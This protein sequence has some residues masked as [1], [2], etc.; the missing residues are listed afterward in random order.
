MP[1]SLNHIHADTPMGANLVADGA[2]FRVWAPQAKAVYVLGDFN[3]RRRND[4]SLLTRDGQGHWRGFVRGVKDR[5]RYMF[6]VVGE[7]G[8]GLKRDPYARELES[9]FPAE[10]IIRRTDF[11]WHESGYVTPPFHE[12]V[13]Y[14]LH[15]GTF[16]T[17]NLPRKG[18]TFLDVARKVP[19]LAELGV[20]ALQLMPIQEFQTSFSLGYNGTDYFS[21]EMD[22]AVPDAELT[23][24][25][26]ALN[27]L[28]TARGLRR[29][30]AKDLRGEMNQL[31]ALVDLCHLHGLAVLLDVVYNH[32]GG[33]FGDQ[34]LYFFD[35]QPVE[36]GQR[37]SLYFTEK[38][39]AGGL[40][41]DFEKP[42]VRDFLI[43]N[44]KFFLREYR[45]DGF[46]YDQ[47]SVIDHDGAPQG[48]RFCQ[49][50]TD[51]LHAQR[52]QAL[53]LAEYWNVNPYVVKP[54][55]E[56]AGFDTTLTDGLRLAIRD[57][58]GNAAAPDERPLNM[59][60]LARSLWPEGFT[61]PWRFV[62]GP[63]NHDIVY[64][65]RELRIARLG[66][67]DHPRSWFARS[68]ARV[69]TGLSLTAP[70]I[71]MLFMGQ[72]FLEDKQWADDFVAHAD[73]LLY[74]EGL[75]RGDKQMQDHLRFTRELL[76]LRRRLPA[77]RGGGVRV[78]HV[79]DANR[80]L[81]FHRWVEGEG[82][83]VIV[84]VSL[85]NFTRV[86]YRIGFP[87]GG[88]WREVFNSDVYE[89]WVNAGVMGN[90]G[91]VTAEPQPLHGYGFSAAVVLPANSLMV[92]AR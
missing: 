56:G 52:P 29:Y 31:K 34:S 6:Y 33:D 35:R 59:S 53:N 14:Q 25:V 13:I 50:L 81:A 55:P 48:W 68:R 79:H 65:G 11:P 43:Q 24:Y 12:F 32:A 92:F 9:P 3:R 45:V 73:L 1:A 38:G 54:T 26:T 22:F 71:P 74:W 58:I 83:D 2:T 87:V 27:R 51:T 47:V 61:E 82:R 62:Q 90:G 41:F 67:P 66:D 23:P 91:L 8:E 84:A 17:P 28:L 60:G 76:A 40:V 85:A 18:G 39:H 36:G 42:E 72:E 75:D 89:G 15:V 78:L 37:H 86:G 88:P 77:L 64:R 4:A 19:Y 46:R 21:P 57:V 70:G 16:F 7:G 10:C 49:D 63:E 30:Q 5:Q 69:A 20:T 80:V 44:A